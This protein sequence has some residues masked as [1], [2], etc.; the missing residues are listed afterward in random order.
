VTFLFSDIEGS[1]RLW[2]ERPDEM[3]VAIA[4]HDARVRAAIEGNGGYVFATGGDGFAAAFGR[5]ADAVAAA[6]Q[7]Q[8]AINDLDYIRV[9]MGINTG[10]VQERGGDY[11]GPPVNR[12]ARLMAAGHG[13]QVLISGVTAELVPGLVLQNLGEHR[14][15]DLG[16]PVLV[17]QL[18]AGEF[19]PLR[20]LDDLPGNLPV[21][22]TS[23]VGRDE[24][25]KAVAESLGEHRLVTLTGVGGVGKTR[26]AL[27]VAAEVVPH[28][29]DGAWLCELASANDAESLVE[30]LAAA[31]DV[32][33]R[34]GKTRQQSIVAFLEGKQLL[35]ILDNCEH[36]LDPTA[37]FAEHLLRRCKSVRVLAT[38]REAMS[39]DGEHVH[40]LRSITDADAFRLFVDRAR[41]VR[42]FEVD[43][44]SRVVVAEICERLDDIPL[45]IELAAARV[46]SMQPA[47]IAA[48]LD[49]RFRLLGG[50]R[51]RGVERHQTLRAT[52]EW[53]YSLLDDT[54]RI[55]FD[56]LGA[57]PA[58][59]AIDA[60]VEIAGGEDLDTWDVI[61]ALASLTRKSM[62]ATEPSDGGVTRYVLL[63]TLRHFGREQLSTHGMI[64][65]VRHRHA[66]YY[67]QLAERLGHDLI[68]DR[69][70][71][72]R[73]TALA[74]LDNLRTAVAWSLNADAGDDGECAIRIV[75][76]LAVFANTA[77]SSGLGAW[78]ERAVAHLEGVELGLRV[79]VFGAA[80]MSALQRGDLDASARYAQLGVAE[81][82]PA[83]CPTPTQAAAAPAMVAAATD[84][85]EAVRLLKGAVRDLE[86]I[87]YPWGVLNLQL[88]AVILSSLIGETKTAQDEM[89]TLLPRARQLANPANL[90]IALYAYASSW[91][92]EN[93]RQ[94][95]GA[96]E[97][98][99]SLTEQGA[100]D[101]VLDSSYMLLASIRHSLGDAPGAIEALL[102]SIELADRVGNRQSVVTAL[103]GAIEPLS[104]NHA[105]DLVAVCIGAIG[106]SRLGAH[107][108]LTSGPD[109]DTRV[110]ATEAARAVLGESRYRELVEEGAAMSYEGV[111]A[112][113]R[114][115][116]ARK[117]TDETFN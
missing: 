14:L 116:L 73:Q 45:A 6:K 60:A 84:I 7:A 112:W 91:W 78:A 67:A 70:I 83:G 49:E 42:D 98:G 109:A 21:Q 86:A 97:E 88:V 43:D 59:F 76:A 85:P 106:S 3:R 2:E 104:T 4:E 94:A 27:Q 15:R 87:D 20:T 105:Y 8:A 10:E 100:S 23:F 58:S 25:V 66:T 101:V 90:V 102:S 61:D 51:R 32:P 41:A 108:I 44:K 34:P 35:L 48:L 29:S 74:E 52:V 68:T 33:T 64:E 24:E 12:T 16:S 95:L 53:S 17:W 50:G 117:A 5:A 92:R 75:A 57:F 38:S 30:V 80:A 37:E 77:K 26:L 31:L 39:V 54:E 19:P 46:V 18:G 110:R 62:I 36:L 13:G 69:E 11:F 28:F 89:A 103:V 107:V 113:A 115:E 22:L 47:E 1:T 111:V 65:D 114:R 81:G 71:V 56:R 40:G 63:E 72:A 96:L 55:V 82:I 99:F 9:R 79:A 93:P